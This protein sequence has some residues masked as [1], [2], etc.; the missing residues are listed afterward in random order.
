[1]LPWRGRGRL[2]DFE[3]IE[4]NH[5][6]VTNQY[7]FRAGPEERRADLILLVN[8]HP[9]RRPWIPPGLS[10]PSARQGDSELL[11]SSFFFFFDQGHISS[12]FRP[13]FASDSGTDVLTY[14]RLKPGT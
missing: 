7:T 4:N 6:V 14:C 10:H 8:G 9:G 3:N 1:M 11:L 12:L 2:V 5:W 13:A